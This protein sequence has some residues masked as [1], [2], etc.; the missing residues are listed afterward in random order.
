M[1]SVWSPSYWRDCPTAFRRYTGLITTSIKLHYEPNK[2]VSIIVS[3]DDERKRKR[4]FLFHSEPV[5]TTL[6]GMKRRLL[7]KANQES[8]EVGIGGNESYD[9]SEVS[10][11]TMGDNVSYELYMSCKVKYNIRC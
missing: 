5:L 4:I 10:N 11:K 2:R 7:T 1:N 6:Q 9:G 3:D 8:Y